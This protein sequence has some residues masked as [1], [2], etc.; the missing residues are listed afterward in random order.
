MNSFVCQALEYG[1]CSVDSG[2]PGTLQNQLL[3]Y[4][5]QIILSELT[6]TQ[7]YSFLKD[8]FFKIQVLKNI[9]LYKPKIVLMNLSQKF[10]IT[11]V[12]AF[13]A[14]FRVV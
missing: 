1:I 4:L 11:S 13:R 9:F 7:L 12:E 14:P 10:L 8:G 5:K 2:E 6:K 3:P